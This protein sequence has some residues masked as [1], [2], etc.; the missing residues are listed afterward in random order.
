MRF[1]RRAA[2]AA[3][4]AATAS[5]ALAG[6]AASASATVTVSNLQVRAGSTV[7]H[8]VTVDASKAPT[9][10]T[11]KLDGHC[12][13]AYGQGQSYGIAAISTQT[14]VV[15]VSPDSVSGLKCG[16]TAA[17]FALTGKSND[18][19][20]VR[21][22][23]VA[24]AP[25]LQ[26]KLAGV[27]LTVTVLNATTSGTPGPPPAHKRP[28]VPAVANAYLDNAKLVAACKTAFA[29]A[30]HHWRGA[31]ISKV[32]HWSAVNKLSKYKDTSAYTDT[33]WTQ[34]VQSQ[35]DTY[36]GYTPTAH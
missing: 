22:D 36:C 3:T 15:T 21:F 24:S 9:S 32:A 18:T 14:S 30:G 12:P 11:V 35:V 28:A 27:T 26:K 23:P 31:L 5:T 6:F 13:A 7:V 20:T 1:G 10:V 34:K 33:T 4:V 29:S 19:T 25:G 8:A 17:T 2:L 16:S